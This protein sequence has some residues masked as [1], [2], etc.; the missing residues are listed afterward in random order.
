MWS[1]SRLARGTVSSRML[2]L[3]VV[4]RVSADW[5]ARY[6]ATL[7]IATALFVLLGCEHHQQNDSETPTKPAIMPTDQD[8]VGVTWTIAR[9]PTGKDL[10]LDYAVENHGSAPIWVLDQIVTTS[11]DGMLT[12][13]DR[14]IVRR[15]SDATTA[16]FV[17]GFTRQLGHAV[18]V[19]PSPIARPLAAGAKLSGTKHVPLPLVSWH[20]FD[21]MI[22]PL[23]G[24]PTKAVFEVSWLPENPPTD[25]NGWEDVPEAAGGTVHLPTIGFVGSSAHSESGTALAIP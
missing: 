8:P 17:A 4:L 16:S 12:L 3:R 22:D 5:D 14:V 10:V 9:G 20:P 1:R 19:E 21:D 6:G 2:G 24:T 25:V 11:R 18:E 13:P 15:G 7:V 23:V